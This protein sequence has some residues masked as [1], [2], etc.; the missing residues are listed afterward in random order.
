MLK[1]VRERV[2]SEQHSVSQ[3]VRRG[4]GGTHL[5][6]P[7]L[8]AWRVLARSV[9]LFVIEGGF[10]LIVFTLLGGLGAEHV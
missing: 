1:D 3:S 2:Y 6:R 7:H 10:R 8:H 9:V 5:E 4:G